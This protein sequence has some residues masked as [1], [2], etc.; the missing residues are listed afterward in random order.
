MDAIYYDL[1]IHRVS[2]ITIYHCLKNKCI[3]ASNMEYVDVAKKPRIRTLDSLRGI[4]SLSVVASHILGYHLDQ[5]LRPTPFYILR[6][7]HEAV[8]FFF[9]LSGYVL[10]YQY[11]SNPAYSYP[12]FLLQ[13]VIRICIPYI[14]SILISIVLLLICK[15]AH[16]GNEWIHTMWIAPITY[17][18]ILNHIFL[19][20]N[21]D[22]MAFN[23][24]IWSLVHEMRVAILFPVL[25]YFLKLKPSNSLI[26]LFTVSIIA[27][28]GV[29]FNIEPQFGFLNGFTYTAYYFYIFFIGA[30]IARYQHSLVLFYNNLT[31]N[32]KTLSVIGAILLYNYSNFIP[33]LLTPYLPQSVDRCIITVLGDFFTT[34]ASCYLVIAAIAASGNKI[35]TGKIPL[36]FGKISYSLYLIHIPVFAFIYFTLY[37]KMSVITIACIGLVASVIAAAVF[38]KYVE[39]PAMKLSKHNFLNNTT[40]N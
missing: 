10:T 14:V 3:I 17:K 22:T 26:I 8:I 6:A 35:L 34:S 38:N 31:S 23:P 1:K 5:H 36:Y 7:G 25:L 18:L 32:K 37:G 21:F 13:R 15:P 39:K 20:N 27:M 19:I 29:F 4:A 16:L 11:S 24:V 40:K 2:C 28:V 30:L 9:V 33:S 12:K